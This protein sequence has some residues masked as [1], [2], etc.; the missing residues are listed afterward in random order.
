MASVTVWLQIILVAGIAGAIGQGAR[1]VVGLKK[2]NDVT[3]SPGATPSDVFNPSRLWVSLLIGFIA[4]VLS[5]L[6]LH[7]VSADMNS[8][9][10]IAF[11]AAGYAGTDFIEG[12]M[13]QLLP[14]AAPPT[15]AAA[16]PQQVG[17]PGAPAAPPPTGAMTAVAQNTA[18]SVVSALSVL[19]AQSGVYNAKYGVWF[20]S[21]VSGGF[22]SSNPDD[23]SV[24]RSIRTNNP[25]ALN[26]SPWQESRRGFVAITP[27]DSAGNRTTIYRTPEHGV[28]SWYYL[29]SDRYGFG[30]AGSFTVT[31][32]AV[33]YAGVNSS[34]D[35]AVR[36]YLTGWAHASGGLLD[37]DTV[38]ALA[39]DNSMLN[40]AK[41]MFGHEAGKASPL[42]DEQIFYGV[43]AERTGTLPT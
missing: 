4:G 13:G 30:T 34:D 15:N 21:L 37:P 43:R 8:Q 23:L 14:G 3:G 12:L 5:A 16:P 24:P 6:I 22:F 19:G 10:I 17:A 29:L 35:P 27:P 38:I 36:A 41:G 33:R 9:S 31:Q 20:A 11:A 18:S 26:I 2:L 40:L 32:L 28:A 42:Q 25:G 39:D 1:A 7:P